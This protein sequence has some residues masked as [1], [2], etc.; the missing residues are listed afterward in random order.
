MA[1]RKEKVTAAFTRFRSAAAKVLGAGE[2]LRDRSTREQ[3]RALAALWL[4]QDGVEA[5]RAEPAMAPAL[6]MIGE[7]VAEAERERAAAFDGWLGHGPR[8]LTDLVVAAAPGAAGALGSA[9]M[10]RVPSPA[11]GANETQ[12]GIKEIP[13]L[14][15]IGTGGLDIGAEFPVAVPLLDESHLRFDSHPDARAAA[16]L[17]VEQLVMRL[18]STFR[19]GVLHVDVWDGSQYGLFPALHPLAA[20]G[21]VTSHDPDRLDDLLDELSERIRRIHSRVLV[22]GD[23]SL[24]EHTATEG[25]RSEPWVVVVLAGNRTA[26]PDEQQRRVQRIARSGLDC[27]IQLVLLDLPITVGAACESVRLDLDAQGKPVG[28]CSMT[29]PHVPV[30]PDPPLPRAEVTTAARKIA[31]VHKEWQATVRT[32]ADLL[33]RV[34]LDATSEAGLVAPIGFDPDGH[35]VELMLDDSA[36]HALI[37]GPSGSGK[38]N[39]LLAM[40]GAL[41][42]RYPPS[43]LHLYLLDFKEGVSFAPFAPGRS[44]GRWLPQARMIGINVNTDREY[45]LAVLQFLTDEMRHRASVAKDYEVSKL[46][47]LRGLKEPPPGPWPRI[48]AVIDEFQFLFADNDALT[49]RAVNLLEDVARRGRSQGIHLVL[50]SQDVGGIDAFW[51]RPGIFEQ[52]VLRIALPRARRVLANLNEAALAL[53]KWHALVNHES[54]VKHAN[55]VARI[56]D[57][58]A[59]SRVLDVQAQVW[60]RYHEQVRPPQ[61][62]DGAKSPPPGPL[63]DKLVGEGARVVVGQVVDMDGSPAI[64]PLPD[65]P[66]RNLAILGAG[67]QDAHR[68]LAT[69][70]LALARTAPAARFLVATL[71]GP[72]GLSGVLPH[73]ERVALTDFRARIE[74]LAAEVRERA[75]GG[76]HGPVHLLVAGADAADPLLERSGTEAL[77]TVIRFGPEVGVHVVGWWRSATRLKQLL[78]LSASVDDMGAWIALDVQG[79]DLL[80]FAPSATVWSPRPGRGLFFDRAQ[81]AR[82]EVV[83]VPGEVRE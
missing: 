40:I 59:G 46:E 44:D 45:G 33:P 83:I 20:T 73:A 55:E 54:G 57:A 62:F 18:L 69:A 16:E 4:R 3:V 41:A 30:R 74:A 7:A 68:V 12:E 1:R 36:P 72:D 15:R 31:E 51:G 24:R 64:V 25:A 66:G 61:V 63:V 76:D 49:K 53:P 77:R 56:P 22:K 29:G 80:P 5:L 50:A 28:R 8:Q 42:A 35:E 65:R 11:E 82:P 52:F 58:G 26:L 75:S 70:A 19:P 10:G 34:W 71:V 48:V 13:E 37:G 60:A 47:E 78:A 2:V 79:G 9:W 17:M 38:T 81:H 27:G 23:L 21:L 67:E 43:E 14:W 39:L 32:F 6:A